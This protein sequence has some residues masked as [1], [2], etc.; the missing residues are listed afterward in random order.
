MNMLNNKLIFD[1]L[2]KQVTKGEFYDEPMFLLW[3]GSGEEEYQDYC[4][5]EEYMKEYCKLAFAED[6]NLFTDSFHFYYSVLTE[7]LSISGIFHFNTSEYGVEPAYY[8]DE[9][10]DQEDAIIISKFGFEFRDEKHE[11]RTE[12]EKFQLSC[13]ELGYYIDIVDK[14]RELFMIEYNLILKDR[15]DK[16]KEVD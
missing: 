7:E 5:T 2:L 3:H 11:Y 6:V 13:T 10:H 8:R 12:E 9:L 16:I 4:D 1:E 15:I 14:A